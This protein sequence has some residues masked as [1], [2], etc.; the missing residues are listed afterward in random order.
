MLFQ[1][2]NTQY[3]DPAALTPHSDT[4]DNRDTQNYH[5]WVFQNYQRIL[6][7]SVPI[8]V[9]A[10]VELRSNCQNPTQLNSTQLNSKVTSV[11]VRH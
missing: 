7:S 4:T 10:P 6:P 9:P 1:A 2:L 11:G 8:A 5:S 3:G